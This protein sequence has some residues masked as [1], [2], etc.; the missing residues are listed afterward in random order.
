VQRSRKPR[1]RLPRRPSARGQIQHGWSNSHAS[2]HPLGQDC[3]DMEQSSGIVCSS[4]RDSAG[5]N[6]F[7]RYACTQ[8][9]KRRRYMCPF[10]AASAMRDNS[11]QT[12]LKLTTRLHSGLG[13]LPRHP[14]FVC[15]RQATVRKLPLSDVVGLP[16]SLP[17]GR[18]NRPPADLLSW[19]LLRQ[20]RWPRPHRV[21][22]RAWNG[23]F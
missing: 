22:G 19:R 17:C 23:R 18:H 11:R 3:P 13:F 20:G 2:S 1:G 4:L 16:R 12:D 10:H 9:F 6:R 7:S 14:P 15:H 5:L 21:C 8:R